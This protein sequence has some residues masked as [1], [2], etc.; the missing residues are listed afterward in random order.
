MLPA[1]R[2]NVPPLSLDASLLEEIF[3]HARPLGHHEDRDELNLGFGFLYYGLVRTLRPR[4][5]V[6]IGSGY[7]FSVVCHALGLKDNGTGTLSFVDPSYSLFRHGPLQTVGGASHWDDPE[8]VRAHFARFGVEDIVRHHKM[9]SEAF[10]MDYESRGHDPIDIAF[11][12]GNHSYADVRHDFLAA[13]QR[14]RK[15]SFILLHDTNIYVREFVGHSGVKKWLRQVQRE[16]D[17]FE[18]LDFPYSSGVAMVRVLRE[19]PWTPDGE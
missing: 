12:D 15:G 13:L 10:F 2:P 5:V 8:R 9:T 7:G 6:V 3:V 17:R 14:A 18:V 19:G 11:I 1:P 4:H 16:P